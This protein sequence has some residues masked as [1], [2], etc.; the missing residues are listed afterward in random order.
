MSRHSVAA[1]VG[2]VAAA[3]LVSV[4]LSRDLTRRPSESGSGNGDVYIT[5][6][7]TLHTGP[8]GQHNELTACRSQGITQLGCEP[9]DYMSSLEGM[10]EPT[11]IRL[12]IVAALAILQAALLVACGVLTL[13]G[14]TRVMPKRIAIVNAFALGAAG[15]ATKLFWD[16]GESPGVAT[17]VLAFAGVIG[18]IALVAQSRSRR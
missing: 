6:K 12:R 13:L 5:Y 9:A 3:A 10:H 7:G 18:V 17:Y 16:H 11:L 8:A 15:A 1:V 2:I 14:R 4:A